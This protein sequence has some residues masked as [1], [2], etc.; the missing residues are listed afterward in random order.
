MAKEDPLWHRFVAGGLGDAT[1]ACL[2]HPADVL[3]VRLQLTGE[4]DPTKR[5]LT[6]RDF[7]HAAKRLAMVEGFRNGFYAGISATIA[8]QLSFS[9][10][11]HGLC[12]VFERKWRDMRQE[13]N[14]S[15]LT[16]L[17]CASVAGLM[18][19][20]VA[21]PT[22]VVL[23]R[24]QADGHWP[25]PQRRE[26]RHVFDGIGRIFNTEGVAALWRGCGPT[27]TRAVLVTTSQIVTY[28][29]AK[30]ALGRAGV[31]DGTQLHMACA[32]TSATVACFATCPV[33]VVKTRVMNMQKSHGISYS[34]PLDC[35]MQTLRSEGPLAFYKGLS[36]TF[37]RLWPHTVLLWLAQEQYGKWLRVWSSS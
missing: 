18:A 5:T 3:K 32:M 17:G 6:A 31:A 8:R 2:S 35:V 29:E 10:L 37:L 23:I 27:A 36:A 21:N 16:R 26:Y 13:S 9:S 20:V 22:D 25:K 33:D 1:A 15:M 19:A 24:M 7:G 34:G 4:G 11:R 14:I 30:I 28:A 12:G